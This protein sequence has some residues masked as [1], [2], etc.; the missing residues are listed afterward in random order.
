LDAD[1]NAQLKK[2][3]FAITRLL[4]DDLV[5]SIQGYTSHSGTAYRV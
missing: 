1:R 2:R 5:R 3:A 4:S